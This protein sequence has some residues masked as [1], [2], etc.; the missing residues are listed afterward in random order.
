MNMTDK[1]FVAQVERYYCKQQRS[2]WQAFLVGCV[3]MALTLLGHDWLSQISH[4]LPT[5]F[6]LIAGFYFSL[7]LLN[8]WGTPADRLLADAVEVLAKYRKFKR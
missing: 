1:E 7:F 3:L 8:Y 5:I 2:K 6:A 4:A